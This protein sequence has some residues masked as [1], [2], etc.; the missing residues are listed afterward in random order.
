MALFSNVAIDIIL[1]IVNIYF[2]VVMISF[3]LRRN[4]YP[5]LARTFSFLD[6]TLLIIT[7][8]GIIVYT[9]INIALVNGSNCTIST[10]TSLFEAI[11]VTMPYCIRG[12]WL[13]EQFNINSIYEEG[14]N[15]VFLQLGNIKKKKTFK[16]L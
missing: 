1:I 4:H 6:L 7:A 5:I 8:F 16:I 9:N 3:Y 12:F 14:E 10:L 13:L 2:A 15:S 11:F